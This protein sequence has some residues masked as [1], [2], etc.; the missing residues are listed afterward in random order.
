MFA[1]FVCHCL[2][3]AGWREA[4]ELHAQLDEDRTWTQLGSFKTL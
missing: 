3:L 1:L 2:T 4:Q